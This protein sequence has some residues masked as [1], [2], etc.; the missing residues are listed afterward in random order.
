MYIILLI[1][2]TFIYTCLVNMCV[3]WVGTPLSNQSV[4]P[5]VENGD[6]GRHKLNLI[7]LIRDLL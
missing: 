7:I 3:K 2:Y 4:R 1:Y 5:L 6:V